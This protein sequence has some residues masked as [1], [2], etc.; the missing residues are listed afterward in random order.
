MGLEI[1]ITEFPSDTFEETVC[2]RAPEMRRC[3]EFC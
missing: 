2:I 1:Q 3:K